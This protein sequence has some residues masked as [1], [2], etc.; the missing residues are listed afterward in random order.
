MFRTWVSA[1]A[2]PERSVKGTATVTPRFSQAPPTK[3]E[4]WDGWPD[5]RESGAVVYGV[6]LCS[7]KSTALL[8]T[9]VA[10]VR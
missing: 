5:T 1:Q 2:V 10:V 4:T 8:L 7:L 6:L 3:S 9:G